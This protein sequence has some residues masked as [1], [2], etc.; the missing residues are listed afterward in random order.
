MQ[1]PCSVRLS[2]GIILLVGF[3]LAPAA[4]AATNFPSDHQYDPENGQDINELCAA[5]HGEFGQGGG[6]GEYP[7]LAGLPA[8]YLAEQLLAFKRLDRSSIAMTIYATDRELPAADLLDI[9]IY[10]SEMD[11]LT[12]MPDVDPDMDSLDKLHLAQRVFN[13]RA[14]EGDTAAGRET[15]DGKCGRCHGAGGVGRGSTPQLAG[16]YSDYLRLQ[17]AGFQSGERR[18]KTMQKSMQSLSADDIE[19]LLAY[20]SVADD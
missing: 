13:V 6:D 20:L 12:R 1:V 8:E 14:M 15:Y 17:I 16:Q 4:P 11:L 3:L 9:S 18:H 10:L 19:A 5:C 2:W 7:R